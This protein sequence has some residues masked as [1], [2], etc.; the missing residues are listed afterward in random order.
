MENKKCVK[1]D[2]KGDLYKAG[3]IAEKKK[4]R[5]NY[6]TYLRSETGYDTLLLLSVVIR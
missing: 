6:N 3:Q 5:V 1:G 2:I 4:G